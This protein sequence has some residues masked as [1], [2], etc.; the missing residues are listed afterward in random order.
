MQF[1][2]PK[3][4]IIIEDTRGLH[5]GNPVQPGGNSRLMLQLQFSNSLFGGSTPTAKFRRIRDERLRSLVGA[6]G[7][8]YRQFLQ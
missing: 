2:A 8:V 1:I 7:D 3:G 6:D 4:T 5:K